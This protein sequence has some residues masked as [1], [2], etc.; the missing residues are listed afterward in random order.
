MPQMGFAVVV[1]DRIK[2]AGETYCVDIRRMIV[3]NRLSMR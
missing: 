2:R 1:A 3:H